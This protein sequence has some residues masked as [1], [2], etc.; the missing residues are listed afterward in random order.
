MLVSIDIAHKSFNNIT[1][2]NNEEKDEDIFKEN[3]CVRNYFFELSDIL[4]NDMDVENVWRCINRG[5]N[6]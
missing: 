5:N 6:I 4:F 1:I 3:Q 2:K